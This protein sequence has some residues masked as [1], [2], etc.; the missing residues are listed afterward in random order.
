MIQYKTLNV[1][2]YNLQL[3]KLKSGIKNN[4][5]V[6]YGIVTNSTGKNFF[7]YCW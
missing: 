1:Q 7:K 6:T 3:R 4:A 5:E 2:I